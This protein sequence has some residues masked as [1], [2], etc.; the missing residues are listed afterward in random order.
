MLGVL[1]DFEDFVYLEGVDRIEFAAE[2]WKLVR[3]N[4]LIMCVSIHTKNLR[5]LRGLRQA[6]GWGRAGGSG[7][8][9][10]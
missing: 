8:G 10:K 3:I 2:F 4:N 5:V 9:S 6:L 7:G 1:K